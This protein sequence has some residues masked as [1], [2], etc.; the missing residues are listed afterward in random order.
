MP[1]RANRATAKLV[2]SD[3]RTMGLSW[4]IGYPLGRVAVASI[5]DNHIELVTYHRGST[6]ETRHSPARRIFTPR[7]DHGRR[8]RDAGDERPTPRAP[9]PPPPPPPP[10]L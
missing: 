8:R 4:I 10:P 5:G 7:P 9:P 6:H 3:L 1:Q 2:A